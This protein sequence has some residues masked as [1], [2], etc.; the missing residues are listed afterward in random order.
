MIGEDAK[1]GNRSAALARAIG[2]PVI[3]SS[4]PACRPTR[5]SLTVMTGL[6]PAI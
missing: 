2:Q 6:V 3:A 5:L 4:T 1:A